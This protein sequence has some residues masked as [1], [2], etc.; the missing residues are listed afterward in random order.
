MNIGQTAELPR[1]VRIT[2]AEHDRQAAIKPAPSRTQ[3]YLTEKASKVALATEEDAKR[4]GQKVAENGTSFISSV[5]EKI[6]NNSR[7]LHS[8]P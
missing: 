4:E 6:V 1:S 8:I 2:K 7:S 5:E 3:T